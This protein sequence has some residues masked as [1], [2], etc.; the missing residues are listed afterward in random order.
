MTDALAMGNPNRIVIIHNRHIACALIRDNRSANAA[1]RKSKLHGF[2]ERL[3][4]IALQRNLD[5]CRR[6]SIKEMNRTLHQGWIGQ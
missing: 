2:V 6:L 1:R 4:I 3:R 5:R